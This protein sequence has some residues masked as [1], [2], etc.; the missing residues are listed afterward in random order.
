[1]AEA[2]RRGK[3]SE[4]SIS[5]WKRQFLEGGKAGLDANASLQPNQR[6]RAARRRERAVEGRARR[7]ARRAARLEEERRAPAGA[8][9]DLEVIRLEAEMPTARFTRLIGVPER[10][11]RRWQQRERAGAAGEGAVAD[12]VGGPDRADR[13]RLRRPVSAVGLEDD[14]DAD[15]GSTATTARTRPSTAR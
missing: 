15:A 9:E 12:A 7:G 13:A 8:Y 1:M 14:R 2:A 10:S 11:Y 6:E 4:Q 5:T 3:A